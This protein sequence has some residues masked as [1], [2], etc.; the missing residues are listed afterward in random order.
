[1][2]TLFITRDVL[3]AAIWL[4]FGNGLLLA[5]LQFRREDSRGNV[6]AVPVPNVRYYAGIALIVLAVLLLGL[7]IYSDIAG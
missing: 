6:E 1:M 2:A 7:Q 3:M 4:S 5:N